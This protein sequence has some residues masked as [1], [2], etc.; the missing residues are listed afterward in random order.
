MNS[1]KSITQGN[2]TLC[3]RI[4]TNNYQIYHCNSC[5]MV[6]KWAL[7]VLCMLY[8]VYTYFWWELL[9]HS[10][11]PWFPWLARICCEIEVFKQCYSRIV[12][13]VLHFL[14]LSLLLQ[15][16]SY[17]LSLLCY[18]KNCWNGVH[19]EFQKCLIVMHNTL[20]L[21]NCL[22]IRYAIVIVSLRDPRSSCFIFYPLSV[23]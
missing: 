9:A 11:P 15:F 12:A 5:T 4:L 21:Y 14:L 23:L 17:T 22:F 2:S 10:H 3:C 8:Y 18:S 20:H 7:T 19:F 6:N 1:G 13:M 16:T